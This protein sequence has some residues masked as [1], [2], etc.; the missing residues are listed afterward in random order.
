MDYAIIGASGGIG[1][2][3]TSLLCEDENVNRIYALSR[4]GSV[5]VHAKVTAITIDI[6]HEASVQNA[7]AIITAPLDRIICATGILHDDAHSTMP[8]KSLKDLNSEALLHSLNVNTVG[9]ALVMKHFLPLL[10]RDTPALFAA[11]SARV[12]S[13]SDNQL[14][15]WYGYRAS[16]AAL[17]M[18]I[19]CAA[20]E[21]GRRY[22]HAAIIGLHPGTVNTGLSKPFQGQVKHDIFTTEQSA[23]HLLDVMHS[24]TAEHSGHCYAW[25]GERIPT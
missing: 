8:E 19:K 23:L 1:Y 4:S 2:A 10:A 3:M 18:M 20:I 17:N 24:M 21:M 6:T 15:G 13:I 7:A 14:G 25:D 9:V 12:G 11:L 5:P 22:K 16:K